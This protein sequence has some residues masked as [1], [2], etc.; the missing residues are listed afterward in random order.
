MQER[1][2][3]PARV[4]LTQRSALVVRGDAVFEHLDIDGALLVVVEPGASL[5][6][7]SLVVRN[8]GWTLV[9]SACCVLRPTAA[10]FELRCRSLQA[11]RR[12]HACVQEAAPEDGPAEERFRV[13][14]YKMQKRAGLLL[15]VRSG[16][17]TVDAHE[18]RPGARVF[19]PAERREEW[20]P[21]C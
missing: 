13:R 4:T 5:T 19:S 17:V 2:P 18:D 3:Q 21:P 20:R 6:V 16:A 10:P 12:A 1:F 8:Q 9:R 7:R 11:A 14:G 15:H